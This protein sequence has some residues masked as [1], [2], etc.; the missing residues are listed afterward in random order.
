MKSN[1]KGIYKKI[2]Q[3][4]QSGK[5]ILFI[6]LPCQVAAVK[7]FVGKRYEEKLYTIDLICHGSPSPMLLERFLNEKGYNIKQIGNIEFRSK[8]N[9]CIKRKKDKA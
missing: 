4:L 6:G 5:K 8:T 3:L 9:F 2:K 7:R 1:P